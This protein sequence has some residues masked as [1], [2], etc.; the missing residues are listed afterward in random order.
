M[1]SSYCR[2]WRAVGNAIDGH[3]HSSI[4]SNLNFHQ[5]NAHSVSVIAF[6]FA[7]LNSTAVCVVYRTEA[8]YLLHACVSRET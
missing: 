5:D 7:W 8:I 4:Q 1:F 6:G 2:R 3:S